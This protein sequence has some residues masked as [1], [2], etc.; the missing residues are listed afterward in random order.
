MHKSTQDFIRKLN[1]KNVHYKEAGTAKNG[2]D[3]LTVSFSCDNI[4]SGVK[5]TFFF[6]DDN[7]DV[8]LRCFDLVK[9]PDDK[10]A[11]CFIAVNQQNKKFRFGKFVLDTG[12]NTIQME[13]DAVFRDHDVGEICYEL[14]MRAVNL[15]DDAYPEFMKAIWS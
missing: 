11:A 2:D 12:D 15:C 5:V 10:V 6:S 4:S 1:E 14:M 3:L 13:M 8:A 9:V 7:E